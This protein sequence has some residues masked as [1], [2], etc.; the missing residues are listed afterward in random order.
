MKRLLAVGVAA[1]AAAAVVVAAGPA[2][3]PK[4]PPPIVLV[5][6]DTLPVSMLMDRDGRVDAVRYPNFAALAAGSTW[7]PN[8]T[9]VH[10]S[11]IKSVPSILDGRWPYKGQ[12]PDAAGHPRTAFQLFDPRWRIAAAE[13]A[14]R[15]CPRRI[16]PDAPPRRRVVD[17]LQSGREGRFLQAIARI[18]R[19]GQPAFHF[20]HTMLPHEPLRYFSSGG[21]YQPQVDPEPG[22]D[23]TES[24]TNEFLTR[25][26]EQ[27]HLLQLA[28]TDRLLGR[29]L[30]RLRDQGLYDDAL[31]VVTADHGM[32]FI[33]KRTPAPPFRVGRL[34]FRRDVSAANAADVLNVPLLIKAPGQDEGR[35]DGTWAR[36]ID[37]L[38]TIADI[39]GVRIPWRVD[40]RSLLR[41][42]PRPARIRVRRNEGGTLS[43]S[44]AGLERARAAAV[45]GLQKRYG[46]GRDS[47]FRLGPH[48]ELVGRP[49]A[50]LR[51]LAA[52]RVRARLR[53]PGLR[54]SVRAASRYRPALVLGRIAGG[55]PGGR[56]LALAVNGRIAVTGWSFPPMGSTGQNISLLLPEN[57]LPAGTSRLELFEVVGGDAVRP[58]TSED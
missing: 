11:T 53:A 19:V 33:R 48:R 25:Q 32:S 20:I 46:T 36:S 23:G 35:V 39:A 30:R 52:G 31:L 7:Y 58:L 45:A 43:V 8:A 27:R 49:V 50:Q 21:T 6:F 47:L 10:D 41:A 13:E 2:K 44:T 51:R 4:G 55:K 28:Y 17:L 26:A 42:R 54:R 14:T 16:C 40:G 57:A 37:I 34:G 29:L 22:L 9:I 18:G 3:G 24:F 12:T 56:A 5:V 15:L 1:L 38:P